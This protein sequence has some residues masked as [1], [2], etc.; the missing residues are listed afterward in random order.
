MFC[1]RLVFLGL[2]LGPF[3]AFLF[4][5][6]GVFSIGKTTAPVTLSSVS[7]EK[8]TTLDT[9]LSQNGV[10]F[11]FV[12]NPRKHHPG[13][14]RISSG[15]HR[16]AD[17]LYDEEEISLEI[18]SSGNEKIPVEHTSAS[19]KLFL[20][21]LE[22]NKSYKTKSE[23]LHFLLSRYPSGDG[24]IDVTRQ[25]LMK[26]QDDYLYFIHSTS[27]AN[28]E[29]FIS[30]YLRSS[31]LPVI[32]PTIPFNDHLPYLRSHA[33]DYVD[34]KDERLI[35]SDAF[36]NK[37]I[38][39]LMY[40]RNPQLPMQ[41]LEKE[42]MAAVDTILGK[43]KVNTKVYTHLTEYLLDGFRKFGFDGVI[44]Y[45]LENYVIKDELCLEE[46][47]SDSL[48]RR[49]QQ[50]KQLKIGTT[51]PD[52]TLTSPEGKNIT[53]SS[54][55]GK[56]KLLVFYSTGCSHCQTM[57]P[58]LREHQMK[59]KDFEVIAVALDSNKEEWLSFIAKHKLN[60]SNV[61]DL[62][63]WDGEAARKYF[64]YATPT[65]FLLDEN[66]KIIGKPMNVKEL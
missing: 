25:Q 28:Q 63:G 64:I 38:E 20:R 47:L 49:I 39:Y 21:F 52:I 8:T 60:W 55:P 27:A 41:L 40:Y 29:K 57:I 26:V 2:V 5:Q 62:K 22:L 33:L 51:A 15:G 42:F 48:E 46:K 35:Q 6:K 59:K 23:L 11:S 18:T 16:V 9:L 61:S 10:S 66:L 54:V 56:K 34:F 50:A 24:F 32:D 19:N 3:V 4:P 12:F 43:A 58:E 53:L 14:Y 45:I 37:A 7:G 31:Q 36:A 44:N 17:F 30:A 65:M 13:L 1:I